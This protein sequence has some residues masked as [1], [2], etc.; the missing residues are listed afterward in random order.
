MVLIPLFDAIAGTAAG[1]MLGLPPDLAS[2]GA[3]AIWSTQVRFVGAGAVAC[4]GVWSIAR[5][6]PVMWRG[7]RSLVAAATSAVAQTF[8]HRARPAAG[9]GDRRHRRAGL[10]MWLIP[11]YEM[12]LPEVG[13]ALVFSFFFVVVSGQIVGDRHDLAAHLRHDHHGT[14]GHRGGAQRARL[15]WTHRNRRDAGGGGDR[16]HAAALAGDTIQDFKCGAL[17]GATRARSSCRR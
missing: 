16:L 13:L 15:R 4:G 7:I 14:P 9:G 17:V 11:A 6:L 3:Q 8:P 10:A 2:Q 12:H 1:S 5:A